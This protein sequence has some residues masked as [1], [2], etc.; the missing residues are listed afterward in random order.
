MSFNHK[1]LNLS[2]EDMRLIHKDPRRL[3][4]DAE[5]AAQS[6]ALA[7]FAFNEAVEDAELAYDTLPYAPEDVYFGMEET[8]KLIAGGH[9]IPSHVLAEWKARPYQFREGHDL[10]P[11]YRAYFSAVGEIEIRSLVLNHKINLKNNSQNRPDKAR[12]KVKHD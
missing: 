10:E 5:R 9:F 6:V 1:S 12:R 8:D 4:S 3:E 2:D 7:K 11:L